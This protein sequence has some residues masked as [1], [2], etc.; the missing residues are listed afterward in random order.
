VKDWSLNAY[1]NYDQYAEG[2]F[3]G[4][5]LPRYFHDNRTVLSVKYAF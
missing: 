5:T 3:V 4:P 2:S 1:W